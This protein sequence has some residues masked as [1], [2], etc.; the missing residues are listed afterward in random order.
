[1]NIENIITA[2]GLESLYHFTT[3]ENYMSILERGYIFS[4]EKIDLLKIENDGHFTGDYTESLDQHRLDGL[5]NYINTSLS[6]PNWYLMEKYK[7]RKDFSDLEWC[8]IELDVSS[9][10][11]TST[12]F[13]VCNAASNT[14]QRYGIIG[15]AKGLDALFQPEVVTPRKVYSRHNLPCYYT[16]DIQAEVLV[17]DQLSIEKIKKC[18]LPSTDDVTRHDRGFRLLHLEKNHF[19]AKPELFLSPILK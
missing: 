5:K 10:S 4:R 16:T 13:S 7:N 19:T 17:K 8:I 12:L 11:I 15:G 14:A 2:R 3:L 1:M 6:R 9:L 18:Y